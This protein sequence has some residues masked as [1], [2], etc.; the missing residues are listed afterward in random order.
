MVE[1]RAGSGREE[2]WKGRGCGCSSPWWC[3]RDSLPARRQMEPV[4]LGGQVG[5][6]QLQLGEEGEVVGGDVGMWAAADIVLYEP[7]GV[8]GAQDTQHVQ[9]RLGVENIVDDTLRREEGGSAQQKCLQE[10]INTC[11]IWCL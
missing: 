8:Q 11:L 7:V 9:V 3:G 2:G 4:H 6:E 5:Q 1:G 10:H